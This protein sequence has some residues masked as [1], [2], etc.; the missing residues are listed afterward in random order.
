MLE[1]KAF[2]GG[3]RLAACQSSEDGKGGNERRGG[4]NK[5]QLILSRTCSLGYGASSRR[6]SGHF[7]SPLA[8]PA[9]LVPSVAG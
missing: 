4:S 6:S 1:L 5:N 3:K 8:V 7:S 9:L 2:G